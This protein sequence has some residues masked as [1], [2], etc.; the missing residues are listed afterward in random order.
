ML[1]QIGD[2]SWPCNPV[3]IVGGAYQQLIPPVTEKQVKILIF[4]NL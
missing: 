3:L 1:D 4:G 2:S